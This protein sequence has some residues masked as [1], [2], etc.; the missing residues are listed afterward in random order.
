MEKEIWK[1]IE[2]YGCYQVSN[3]GNVRRLDVSY[4][5]RMDVDGKLRRF[6]VER[7]FFVSKTVGAHGYLKSS[8]GSYGYAYVHRL[9]AKAFHPLS[10][11]D[12]LE[13]NHKDEDKTNNRADNLEWV[14]HREKVN[15]GTRTKRCSKEVYQYTLDGDFVA[16]YSSTRDASRKV[17]ISHSLVARCC[18]KNV[19][20]KTTHGYI[21]SYEPLYK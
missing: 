4:D 10:S 11:Y 6:K 19:S 8:L 3:F 2:G 9:V 20:N 17:G 7:Y 21:W 1:D 5:L 15:Y 16:K 12:G 13:V 14:T 18:R